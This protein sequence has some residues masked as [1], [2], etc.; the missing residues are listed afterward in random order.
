MAGGENKCLIPVDAGKTIFLLPI[1]SSFFLPPIF[2]SS[3]FFF[4]HFFL[5][6]LPIFFHLPIFL[7]LFLLP[8]FFFI[9]ERIANHLKIL[10]CLFSFYKYIFLFFPNAD[11][12][13]VLAD[14]LRV[15][16]WT[17]PTVT[18]DAS[19]RVLQEAR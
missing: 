15:S 18:W 10:N 1:F 8:I 9:F 7:L 6:F 4:F 5:F 12:S 3:Y 13:V 14:I 16:V 19:R 2:S 17:Q 11:R